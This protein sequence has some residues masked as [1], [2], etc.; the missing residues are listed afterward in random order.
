MFQEDI[1]LGLH[2]FVFR[3]FRKIAKSDYQL[4]HVHLSVRMEQLGF[5]WMDFDETWYLS[6]FFFRKSVEKIQ[7]LLNSDK[8]NGYFK[9]RRFDIFNDSFIH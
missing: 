5:L 2:I 8:N 1:Y 3:R 7:V 4:P 6:F 9:W